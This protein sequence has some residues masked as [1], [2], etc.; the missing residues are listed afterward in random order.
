MENK[1][2]QIAS[3]TSGTSLTPF[4]KGILNVVVDVNSLVPFPMDLTELSA[5]S[6]DIFRLQPELDYDALKFLFDAFKKEDIVWDRTKGIQN[7]F[8]GLKRIEKTETGYRV[9]RQIW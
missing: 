3:P 6:R 8:T 9:L 2:L 7:I 5:W 4:E 1:N